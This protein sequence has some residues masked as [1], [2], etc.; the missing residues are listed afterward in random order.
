MTSVVIR[1]SRGENPKGHVK[2]E[3]VGEEESHVKMEA[4]VGVMQGTPG[5]ARYW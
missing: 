4:D 3:K 1:H 5:A 2:K